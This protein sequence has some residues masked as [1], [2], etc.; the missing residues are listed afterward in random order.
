MPPLRE[1]NHRIPLID[2][3]MRYTYHLPRC[4][5]SLK[6]QLAEKIQLYTKAGWWERASV[7]Q[8][9][10]MLCIPK[11]NGK[12]RT[13]VDCRKRNNNTVK[14]VT[15]FPDQDQI[16]M[17]VARAKY[18][19]KIDLSNAYEQVRI[20]PNDVLKIAF[21]TVFS[22]FL[23]HVMQQGDCNTPAT[24]QRLI[25]V[26][27]QEYIARI[28]HTY[29]DDA[30]VYSDT[31]E[32]HVEH[33]SLV[34]DALVKADFYLERDKVDLFAEKLDCLG[35]IIDD[36]GVHADEDKMACICNWRKP[37]NLNEIQR[38]VGLVE[39]LAPFM[40]DVSAYTTPLMGIQRNGHPFLWR[41]IHDRCFQ[42]IKDLACKY[43]ILQPID[44]RSDEPIWLIC[45]TS[46]YSIGALYSQG[47]T[48]QGCRPAGFM[49]KKLTDTQHNYWTFKRETLAILEVLLKWEDKLFGFHFK[50]ITDHEALQFLRMQQCLS[51]RQMRWMDYLSRFNNE[52]IYVK[53]SEN[54]VADCLSQYY[55]TDGG[56]EAQKETVEWAMANIRLDPEGDDL[57]IDRLRE[58]CLA[59]MR[60]ETPKIREPTE[61]RRA[62]A[63]AL[64]QHAEQRREEP[65]R[66]PMSEDPTLLDSAGDPQTL[67]TH[68]QGEHG[69][70]DC[71]RWGYPTDPV[72]AKVILQ[73]D[74]HKG[75]D[76]GDGLI[77]LKVTTGDRVLCL[78]RVDWKNNQLTAQ[79]IEHA[80]KM[81]GHFGAMRTA[82][83][84]HRC[85][86]WPGLGRDV[87][88]F[89][90]SCPV[91][92]TTKTDNTRPAGLLHSLPIPKRP[93]NS[94]VMDFVSPFP[95]SSGANYLWVVLCRLTSLVHLV[96]VNTTIRASEL[97]WVFI[98]EIMRL[99]GLPDTIVSDRDTK[100]TSQFWRETDG[101]SEQA[102]RNVSQILRGLVSPDQQDWA[103][104]L[105]MVE[106]AINSSISSSTGFAPF[107][108]TYRYLPRSL[109]N[110]EEQSAAT[111]PGVTSFVRR[112]RENLAMAHDAIIKACVVQTHHTNKRRKEG[113]KY[114]EGDLVYLSMKNLTLPKGRAR[115]LLPKYIGPMKIIRANPSTDTYTLE[116][117]KQ[118]QE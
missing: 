73:P 83:Y 70:L 56:D 97:T 27:L 13:V 91:C 111:A 33:V 65:T 57:P 103:E 4:P 72:L 34:L 98:R 105:L 21:S 55:E 25:T 24:F 26:T 41:E 87:D 59:A 63:D 74:H 110:I 3:G 5:D 108:L 45:D 115:K 40:P 86:W 64:R 118:L 1:V 36:R 85:F 80:H 17:D 7:S 95:E 48:W 47:P 112:V 58:L 79:V 101:A 116:L 31:I 93:W 2:E 16:Q 22:T 84:I 9:A 100:F 46:L 14:D 61:E 28:V 96:L 53:G 30:F 19:S 12:I 49:S 92:Q 50:V 77:Y 37:T 69:F 66:A 104:K 35:H 39:Y 54:K 106:F 20:D 114:D 15:P 52:I 6:P 51:S 62:E 11:K 78:P 68:F 60:D 67:V 43:P 76:V 32:E 44:P 94:I 71:I 29:L 109:P 88:R 81:L 10:P 23:S 107:E 42:V 102:I 99:H 75:F 89:C 82:D 113:G 90:R 8:A 117:P 38:F 18:R